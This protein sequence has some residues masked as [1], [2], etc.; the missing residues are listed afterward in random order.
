[1]ALVYVATCGGFVLNVMVMVKLLPA[2]VEKRGRQEEHSLGQ[3]HPGQNDYSYS[4]STDM[5]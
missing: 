3:L 2:L 5:P 4:F 1:M